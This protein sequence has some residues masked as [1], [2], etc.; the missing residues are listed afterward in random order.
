MKLKIEP[1]MFW[2]DTP[3]LNLDLNELIALGQDYLSDRGNTSNPYGLSSYNDLEAILSVVKID[4]DRLLTLARCVSRWERKRK[5][6]VCFHMT[7]DDQYRALT[8][9]CEDTNKYPWNNY[10]PWLSN[11]LRKKCLDKT[12]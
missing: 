9:L 11:L 3:Q 7:P 5:W 10:E 1:N 4:L 12:V 8:W 6:Q 2:E